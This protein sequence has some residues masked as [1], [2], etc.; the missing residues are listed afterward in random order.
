MVV[1]NAQPFAKLCKAACKLNATAVCL[2]VAW[3]TRMGNQVIIQE[4]SSPLADVAR[5]QHVSLHPLGELIYGNK[6]VAISGPRLIEI[7]PLHIDALSD[8]W[9]TT[10]VCL[11]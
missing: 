10:F 9:C 2:D 11:A 5:A 8:E 6:E 4:L 1:D 7:D 3:L